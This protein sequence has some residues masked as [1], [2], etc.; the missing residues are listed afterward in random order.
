MWREVILWNLAKESAQVGEGLE[1][2]ANLW[3][4]YVLPPP[5]SLFKFLAIDYIHHWM[6]SSCDEFNH[7]ESG[8]AF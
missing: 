3:E 8:L 7:L 4:D 6:Y 2:T 1:T 5:G